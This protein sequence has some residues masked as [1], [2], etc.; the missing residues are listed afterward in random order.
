MNSH[1]IKAITK[2]KYYKRE[3]NTLNHI[4]KESTLNIQ[5]MSKY[6]FPTHDIFIDNK[7]Y[8]IEINSVHELTYNRIGILTSF[9]LLIHSLNSFKLI[10][11]LEPDLKLIL[12]EDKEIGYSPLVDFIILKNNDLIIWN[13]IIIFLY[14]LQSKEYKLFQTINEYNQGT[15]KSKYFNYHNIFIY[16]IKSIYELSNGNLVSC[17][18]HGLKIYYKNNNEYH[19]MSKLEISNDIVKLVEIKPNIL[20]L[21]EKK[22]IGG[23]CRVDIFSNSISIY[24]VEK[25]NKTF[26]KSYNNL[27]NQ[28]GNINYLI[29]NNYLLTIY[30]DDVDI[31]NIDNNF[32]LIKIKNEK[33]YYKFGWG[34]KKLKT[35]MRINFLCDFY[36]YLF[37]AK[38]YYSVVKIYKFEY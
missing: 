30:G 32:E 3:E 34:E 11:K 8:T 12:L 22:F 10:K 25:K 19:L 33:D 5:L 17:N 18:T 24:D 28:E 4:A 2:G 21:F 1:L 9:Y 27:Q 7:R 15:V 23:G 16:K 20:I 31:F 26:L 35:E 14:N 13:S 38:D 6:S 36:D 37:F 29:K